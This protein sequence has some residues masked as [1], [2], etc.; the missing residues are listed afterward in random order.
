[1]GVTRDADAVKA[2]ANTIDKHLMTWD[3]NT[4]NKDAGV[5]FYYYYYATLCQFQAGGDHWNKWNVTMKKVLLDNQRK[6]GPMDGTLND[7][8]GSW[9]FE[10]CFF[11]KRMGRVYT[12][13][14]GALCLEVYYRYL[15]VYGK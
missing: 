4:G 8:D 6:G 11:G 15:P 9:D 10:P 14:M 2:A 13:A 12:T 3:A 7:V 5:N 1:M